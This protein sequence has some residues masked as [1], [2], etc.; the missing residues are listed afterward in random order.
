M[1]KSLLCILTD[2][3]ITNSLPVSCGNPGNSS[4]GDRLW[5]ISVVCLESSNACPPEQLW[6]KAAFIAPS[7]DVAAACV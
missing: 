4:P 3:I 2:Y 6:H 5:Q 7:G 1:N